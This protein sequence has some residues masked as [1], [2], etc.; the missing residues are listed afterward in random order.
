[1]KRSIGGSYQISLRFLALGIPSLW[2]RNFL[3]NKTFH[4]F[5]SS[6]HTKFSSLK[7]FDI[8]DPLTDL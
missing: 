8:A 2:W 3:Q 6:L 7:N 4:D 5:C 1:M